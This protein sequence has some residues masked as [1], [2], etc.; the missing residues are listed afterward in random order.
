[1]STES[2]QVARAI[3]ATG[4][5]VLA[6]H[7]RPD[8]D[9]LGSLLGLADILEGMG[10]RVVCYLEE[11]VSPLYSFLPR[12]DQVETD[13][14]RVFAFVRDCGDDIMGICLDCGDLER[15]G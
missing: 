14:A 10:K 8:G 1:M 13:L 4:N 2:N 11:P 6:T 5:I 15:L 12:R 3:L 9:A 7:I